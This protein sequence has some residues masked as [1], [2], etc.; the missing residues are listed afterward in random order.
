MGTG[1][2]EYVTATPEPQLTMICNCVNP[3]FGTMLSAF[4]NKGG[5][6]FKTFGL[7]LTTLLLWWGA[8]WCTGLLAW[9]IVGGMLG[10]LLAGVLYLWNLYHSYLTWR[11]SRETYYS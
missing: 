6:N 8:V 2:S 1:Y 11:V 3:G 5:T 9:T 10:L 4:Y 7:G